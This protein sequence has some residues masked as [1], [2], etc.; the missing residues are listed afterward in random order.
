MSPALKLL[1]GAVLGAGLGAF[2]PV[3][4]ADPPSAVVASPAPPRG[5]T[6]HRTIAAIPAE[7]PDADG[8]EAA[9]RQLTLL[10]RFSAKR[11]EGL[12]LSARVLGAPLVDPGGFE[13]APAFLDGLAAEGESLVVQCD[14]YPCHGALLIPGPAREARGAEVRAAI[15]A[16]YPSALVPPWAS[17]AAPGV[18][19][20]SF[21]VAATSGNAE[22]SRRLE[23]MRSWAA[24]AAS[25]A[26]TAMVEPATTPAP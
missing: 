22:E 5:P 11:V 1:G 7:C 15:L 20:V 9:R 16:K 26:A 12:D 17:D 6:R 2:V 14:P 4:A 13:G 10:K 24:T 23:R 8:V 3:P 21:V 25:S 18:A 19:A